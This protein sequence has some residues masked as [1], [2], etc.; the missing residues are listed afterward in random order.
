MNGLCPLLSKSA[1][2]IDP[3]VGLRLVTGG[4]C[5]IDRSLLGLSTLVGASP[6]ARASC[7]RGHDY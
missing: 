7:F 4:L 6:E 2:L 3:Q 1:A 5:G